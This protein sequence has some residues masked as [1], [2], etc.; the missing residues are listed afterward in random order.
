MKT[1]LKIFLCGSILFLAATAAQ[2]ECSCQQKISLDPTYT[3]D[4]FLN[5]GTSV[6]YTP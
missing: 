1:I 6:I 4:P 2:A 5:R 3:M